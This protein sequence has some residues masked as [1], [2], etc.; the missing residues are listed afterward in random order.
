MKILNYKILTLKLHCKEFLYHSFD[1]FVSLNNF[2]N[3]WYYA[4][5]LLHGDVTVT[6]KEGNA[7]KIL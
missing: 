7:F 2:S 6:V 3:T 5:M 1:M 4:N